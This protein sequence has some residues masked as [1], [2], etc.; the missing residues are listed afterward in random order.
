[1]ILIDI[2][3]LGK[4]MGS[5]LKFS[6]GKQLCKNCTVWANYFLSCDRN[7]EQPRI[8]NPA[9]RVSESLGCLRKSFPFLFSEK[10][11]DL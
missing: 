3:S 9:V 10:L 6:Q 5:C 1:M 4:Q 2:E 11:N 7:K 8:W